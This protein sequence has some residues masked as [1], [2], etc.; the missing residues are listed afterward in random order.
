MLVTQDPQ[1]NRR[2]VETSGTLPYDYDALR[3]GI[4]Y[5]F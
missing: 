4:N 1:G 3:L 2:G 5:R